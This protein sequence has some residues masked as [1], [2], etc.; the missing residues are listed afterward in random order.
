MKLIYEI[1]APKFEEFFTSEY[2]NKYN[3]FNIKLT[4]RQ[5]Y[6]NEN[7]IINECFKNYKNLNW[8]K[9]CFFLKTDI[10]GLV[11]SDAIIHNE[12]LFKKNWLL[13]PKIISEKYGTL[14][15]INW[16]KGSVDSLGTY[17]YYS[18]D[19]I[20]YDID[21]DQSNYKTILEKRPE[22][23]KG[24]VMDQIT[25]NQYDSNNLAYKSKGTPNF[26]PKPNNYPYESYKTQIN[27]VYL[28]NIT[29]P[30]LASVKGTRKVYSLRVKENNLEWNDV[31]N[32]FKDVINEPII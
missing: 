26:Y 16:I 6:I 10:D 9:I 7:N 21:I 29:I 11:H 30:H 19:Q 8:E 5:D 25:N 14:W 3:N 31:V 15:A 24:N 27:K 4:L 1:N 23:I 17:N 18:W 13:N 20:T 32:K 12:T 28:M 22:N 2:I